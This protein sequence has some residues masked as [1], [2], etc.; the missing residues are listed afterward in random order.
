MIART[1]A[2]SVLASVVVLLIPA[3]ASSQSVG[4]LAWIRKQVAV[5]QT[6]AGPAQQAARQE[7]IRVADAPSTAA[8]DATAV[9]G[10]LLSVVKSGNA[11]AKVNAAIVAEHLAA[12]TPSPALA[13]VATALL[14]DPSECVALWGA[15]TARPLI[16]AGGA[17]AATLAPQMAAAVKAHADSGPIAEEAYAAL[18]PADRT[19]ATGAPRSLPVVLGILEFRTAQYGNGGAPPSPAAEAGVPVFLSD[20]SW[21]AANAVERRRILTD[22]GG[23]A[24]AAARSAGEGNANPAI[25]L[26]A[27]NA[28]NGVAAIGTDLHDNALINAAQ[29]LEGISASRAPELIGGAQALEA[30]VKAAAL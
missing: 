20:A 19:M 6:G 22:L 11:R 18:I 3:V 1:A 25:L 29:T 12:R 9:A 7:L 13:P 10:S 2:S 30:A 5:I 8:P 23:L 27:R 4:S 14:G 17:A 24:C 21:P 26:A 28:A 16:A 15:K